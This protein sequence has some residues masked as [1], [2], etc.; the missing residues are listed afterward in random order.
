[1][2]TYGN[3]K[4]CKMF[5]NMTSEFFHPCP[6]CNGQ[7]GDGWE[8]HDE[9]CTYKRDKLNNAVRTRHTKALAKRKQRNGA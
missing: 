5:A 7:I 1:M 2:V 6:K 4:D 9:G 3:G 8:E